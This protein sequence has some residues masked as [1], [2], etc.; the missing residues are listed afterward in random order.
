MAEFEPS[1][2]VDIIVGFADLNFFPGD[3]WMLAFEQRANPLLSE[4]SKPQLDLIHKAYYIMD[5]LCQM[6]NAPKPMQGL[7]MQS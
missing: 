6:L 2:L 4:F 3:D 7:P 1:D 5:A